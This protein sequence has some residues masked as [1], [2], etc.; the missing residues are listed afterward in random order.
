MR[1]NIRRMTAYLHAV[2][3]L[4]IFIPAFYA[5]AF[6][7]A[8]AV[9]GRLYAI[10]LLIA[11]PVVLSGIAIEKCRSLW[12]YLLVCVLIL[13]GTWAGTGWIGGMVVLDGTVW[14]Y[15][16]LLV[17]ETAVVLVNR[18]SI[19]MHREKEEQEGMTYGSN[20]TTKTGIF[21]M[22]HFA[23]LA[24]FGVIYVTGLCFANPDVCNEALLSG[25]CYLAAAVLYRYVDAM[26]CYLAQNKRVH[27]VPAKRIYGIGSGMIAAFL[28]VCGMLAAVAMLLAEN[29]YYT[30][31]RDIEFGSV[32]RYEQELMPDNMENQNMQVLLEQ[33]AG[34]GKTWDMPDWLKT[35]GRVCQAAM[36]LLAAALILRGIRGLFVQFRDSYEENGDIIEELGSA[37][38]TAEP[39]PSGRGQRLRDRMNA[40]ERIRFRYRSMIR[41]N[42]K[43]S[44]APYE[45]PLEIEIAAGI[46]ASAKAKELHARYEEARYGV[47]EADGSRSRAQRE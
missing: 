22:P 15:R 9:T 13:G 37:Y 21:D 17:I 11:V 18:L 46:A 34:E 7:D 12:T 30:D 14:V 3:I 39:L 38:E 6:R 43:G 29:R 32:L 35:F 20:Q 31:L 41:K 10:S 45:T 40:R 23:A 1:R 25:V 42:R 16:I 24:Y 36:V 28:A 47:W 26:E 8:G 33:I 2:L 4:A 5:A 44:P 27:N 19:R